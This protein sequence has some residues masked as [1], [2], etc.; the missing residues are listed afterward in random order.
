MIGYSTRDV[1]Q[2]IGLT[3]AQIR[4]C[5]YLGL[6]SPRR[7]SRNEYRFDFSDMVLLRTVKTLRDASIP[8]RRALAALSGLRQMLGQSRTLASVRVVA[9]GGDVV[10]V[11]VDARWNA[12]SGQGHLSIRADDAP[13]EGGGIVARLRER[14]ADDTA[15]DRFDW[16]ELGL[17]LEGEDPIRAAVA[18]LVALELDPHFVD[19][20]V[21]LARLKHREGRRDDAHLHYQ[22]ALADDPENQQALFGIGS[23]FH[24]AGDLEA[25]IDCYTRADAVADAH[26]Q[27]SRIYEIRGDRLTARRHLQ[28]HRQLLAERGDSGA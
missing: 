25:A 8:A 24:E 23:L 11:D 18:Y 28:R 2:L 9:D 27:L 12:L 13:A 5:V 20:H 6:V 22:R 15:P 21:H 4:R 16:Y 14:C 17:E 1:S 3:P 7:G 10:M 26:Y 19:A